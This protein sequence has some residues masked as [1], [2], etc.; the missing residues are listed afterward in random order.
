MDRMNTAI[1][2]EGTIHEGPTICMQGTPVR[3]SQWTALEMQCPE[4]K[5]KQQQ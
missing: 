5:P 1:S 2:F 4:E 3:V